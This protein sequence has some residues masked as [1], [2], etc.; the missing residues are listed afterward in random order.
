MEYG[1]SVFGQIMQL[2]CSFSL[3]DAKNCFV[4]NNLRRLRFAEHNGRIPILL[5]SLHLGF[6]V[7]ARKTGLMPDASRQKSAASSGSPLP[8]PEGNSRGQLGITSYFALLISQNS[9]SPNKPILFISPDEIQSPVSLSL[10]PFSGSLS[11]HW[12]GMRSIS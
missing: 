11:Q 10:S 7:G 3:L 12:K 9:D 1:V 2:F 6:T 8:D 5:T 4:K